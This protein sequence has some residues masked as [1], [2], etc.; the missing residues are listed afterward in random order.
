MKVILYLSLLFGYIYED[1]DSLIVYNDTLNICG[2]HGY[3]IKVHISDNAQLVIRQATGAPDSTG[4]LHL[5]APLITIDDSSSIEG[6]GKGYRGGY[7]NSHPWGYGPGGGSAGGV[8]GGAGGGGAYGGN[9]GTG[10]DYYG[11]AGGT[12]YG[13]PTDTIVQMGSGGGAGRLSVVISNGGHG[14][15]ALSL[16]GSL[17]QLI[18]SL[19]KNSG[20][21][22]ETGAGLEASGGGAG[23]GVIIW[24]D[25]VMM[26]TATIEAAGGNGGDAA[27]G[28]GGGGSGGRIKILFSSSLDTSGVTYQVQGGTG[29]I[30]DPGLPGSTDGDTG[31]IH[32][33]IFTGINEMVSVGGLIFHVQPNPTRGTVDITTKAAPLTIKIFDIAGR[34]VN[35]LYLV[36]ERET[37]DLSNLRGGVYFMS[38]GNSPTKPYKIVLLD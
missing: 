23:G 32:I 28:G 2:N 25:T 24:A 4:W 17:V 30:G 26:H 15:A 21:N 5:F 36:D 16:R 8:S 11:G 35:S 31:T 3:A 14:G 6:S 29:G 10:G 19:V 27:F 18:S 37:V 12:P 20:Q 38:V 9:G 7:M 22:G 1:S 34:L 33:D 13:D